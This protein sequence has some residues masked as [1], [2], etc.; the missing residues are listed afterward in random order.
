MYPWRM[1]FGVETLD[2]QAR[3]HDLSEALRPS[4]IIDEGATHFHVGR[5]GKKNFGTSDRISRQPVGHGK[6]PDLPRQFRR[7]V[8]LKYDDS[9]DFSGG[10][11]HGKGSRPVFH[12]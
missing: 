10:Q 5:D 3:S 12:R 2:G 4:L 6:Q 8:G 1:A 9:L 11:R 7:Y